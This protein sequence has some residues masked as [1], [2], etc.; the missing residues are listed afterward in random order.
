MTKNLPTPLLEHIYWQISFM[1]AYKKGI[2]PGFFPE[3]S[4][5][6]MLNA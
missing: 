1:A 2:K 3:Y 5:Q 4:T 6:P